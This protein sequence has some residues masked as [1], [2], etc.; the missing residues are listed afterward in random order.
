MMTVMLRRAGL[1][2]LIAS[3]AVTAGCT[4]I[5][6]HQGYIVDQTLVAAVQPG[7]DNRDSVARTLGRPTFV[8]QFD[9]NEWYYVAR[10]TRQLAFAK[11]KPS[12]QTVL[13][14]RFDAAGNVTD[15]RSTGLEQVASINPSNKETPTL[16]RDRGFFEDLFGN[17]GRVGAPGM[18]GS[19]PNGGGTTP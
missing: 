8:G 1:M 4:R 9:E 12:A 15:V 6:Q 14:V 13:R 11:P 10:D 2:L 5:R 7:V 16:G 19:T 18:G 17:I 3:T